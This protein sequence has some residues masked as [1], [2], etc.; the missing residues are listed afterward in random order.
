[1]TA[2]KKLQIKFTIITMIAI[3]TIVIGVFAVVT[4]ENYRMTNKQL[5]TL[6][7]LI[8]ENDGLI[9]DLKKENQYLADEAKYS[10]RYFIIRLDSNGKII[11]INLDHVASISHEQAKDMTTEILKNS[12]NIG[13]FHNLAN[14]VLENNKTYG[15]FSN[16]KYKISN[17]N[18]EKLIV[19]IDCQM[20]LQSFKI[21]TLRS[22]AVTGVLL[23]IILVIVVIGSKVILNP[24]FRSIES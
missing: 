4:F 20:Q 13:F 17:I 7:N 14:S 8:S 3:T 10:T 18:D 15:F 6:L 23:V 16:Y 21:A 11:E 5:D 24:V 9:P 1:M 2:N 19:F 22:L 12:K